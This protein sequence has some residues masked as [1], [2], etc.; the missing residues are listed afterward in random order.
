MAIARHCIALFLFLAALATS[1]GTLVVGQVAPLTGPIATTGQRLRDGVKLWFDSVNDKG[2]INGSK[3]ELVVRDDGYQ[4]AGTVAATHELIEQDHAVAL[5]GFA[6]TANIGE[7][8]KQHVLADANIPLIAPYTGGTP[9]RDPFNPWIF[10]IRASYADEAEQMVRAVTFIGV[11][12]VGVVYQDDAFGQ[13]G[14]EGVRAALERRHL[15]PAISA[16][17]PRASGDTA[18]AVSTMLREQP[19]AIL[20]VAVNK[21]TASFIKAYRAAGGAAQLVNISVVDPVELVRLAGAEAISGLG[22][23]QVMP[24]PYRREL[25]IVREYQSALAK[26]GADQ[27]PS[28]AALEGFIGAKVLTEGLRRAGHD[29][30]RTQVLHALESLHDYDVGGFW[31][32]FDHDRRAGSRFVEMT[33][34]QRDGTLLK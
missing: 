13:S 20:L 18:A 28:Y 22:I 5:I 21:A 24:F 8:L 9:L 3:V 25:P 2:G 14:L 10:H 16:S 26:Y 19:Q 33:V 30:S 12:R 29:P 23:T 27:T 31:V 6:G 7:L 15:P 11:T 4:V 34:V 1:A 17:Y 32:N